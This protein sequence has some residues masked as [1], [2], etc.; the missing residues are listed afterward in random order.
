MKDKTYIKINLIYFIAMILVAIIFVLGAFGIVQNEWLSTFLI[1]IVVM[2]ALPL[3]LYSL[4]TKTKVKDTFKTFGIKIVS[5]AIIG[6]SIL[7]GVI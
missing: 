2:F 1:Q 7:L 3:L 6:F 5:P 4:F